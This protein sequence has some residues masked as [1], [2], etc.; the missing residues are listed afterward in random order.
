M[1]KT[2]T[3]RKK[4]NPVNSI[5]SM[6]EK[7]LFLREGMEIEDEKIEVY[8]LVEEFSANSGNRSVPVHIVIICFTF[9]LLVLTVW[10]TCGIQSDIDRV[11]VGIEEF[12][13][14]NL[15]EL[16]TALRTA[17]GEFGKIDEK[18]L[19]MK[20]GMDLE[21]EKIMQQ[22][23]LEIKKV[24]KSGLSRAKK[25]RLIEK[26][27]AEQQRRLQESRSLYEARIREK[28]QEAVAIQGRVK[29][30]QMNVLREKSDYEKE[31][32][33]KLHAYKKTA[34][35]KALKADAMITARELEYK[36]MMENQKRQ[37]QDLMK[38]YD[39]EL[40]DLRKALLR[41]TEKS[42][43]IEI[44]L[45]RY[46]MAITYFAKSRGEH[47]FVIDPEPEGQMLVDMNPYINLKTR[48]RAYV[49]NRDNKIIALVE[50]RDTG[51]LVRARIIKRL[52]EDVITPFDKILIKNN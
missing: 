45:G 35:L 46:R 16:L 32:M 42:S 2:Y 5:E 24:E 33:L 34:D 21:I 40:S 49:L 48:E 22:N 31:V 37:L 44:L 47:G 17:K 39:S 1:P 52:R 41:E 13:D 15:Q 10:F 30:F 28:E 26:M 51:R 6:E 43:T 27:R 4:K 12:K 7:P 9:I 14:I 8:N 36:Q 23:A 20:Q 50:L 3:Q 29:T 18:I 19:T 25:K 11:S 38:K